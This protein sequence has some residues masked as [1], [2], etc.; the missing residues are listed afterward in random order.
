MI[1][2]VLRHDFLQNAFL[3]GMIIGFISPMI[4]VFLV[5]RRLSLIA[6]TLA[7]VTLSGVAAGLFLKKHV[8]LFQTVHP[9][10]VGML[11]SVAGGFFV[12][13]LRNVYR[14]YQELALP[15]ILSAGTGLAVVLISLANG[16]NVD[17]YGYLFGSLI[18]VSR[19]DLS[20]VAVAGLIVIAAV[21]ALYKELFYLSFDEEGAVTSGIS[22]RWIH[23]VFIL[24]VACVIAVSMNIVGILLVS[25][26]MTL[27]V[28][29]GLQ[30]SRSFKQVFVY[31]VLFAETAVISGLVLSY[32]FDLAT[33]GT[34]VVLSA[35]LLLLVIFIKK[36]FT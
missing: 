8:A 21:L 10:Y 18:A 7:H 1:E 23:V 24:L 15:I 11:F 16:F 35:F 27:P 9:I 3:S 28:A 20:I 6:D 30:L 33:G 31:A 4:G 29:C 36:M 34:I 32:Y 25:S 12:E 2:D 14:Y 19:A 22:K 26:M 13:R 17:V 5:V